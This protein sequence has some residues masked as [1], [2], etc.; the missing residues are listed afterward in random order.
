MTGSSATTGL[1]VTRGSSEMTEDTFRLARLR[2]TARESALH[3]LSSVRV[4]L[5]PLAAE[6][7]GRL[8][9][10]SVRDWLARL[11]EADTM[12]SLLLATVAHRAVDSLLA[13]SVRLW[14]VV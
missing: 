7:V 5:L 12:S 13:E 2:A 14:L 11:P 9:R 3:C 8:R 1:T 10:L 6:D 4:S